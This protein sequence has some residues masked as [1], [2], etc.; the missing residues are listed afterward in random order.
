VLKTD[1]KFGHDRR[2]LKPA[3]YQWVFNSPQ[4]KA[5]NQYAMVLARTKNLSKARL[6]LIIA[7][8]H[9]RLATQRN[10][11]K[12]LT[13]ESF[14]CEGPQTP[15]DCVFLCKAGIAELSNDDITAV[16]QSLWARVDERL[17]ARD[18]IAKP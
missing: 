16:L 10:R 13:R 8:K 11:I 9:V 3:D 5:H 4:A 18:A 15:V 1:F 6:G 7:K 17:G 14:R 12:R 2:L